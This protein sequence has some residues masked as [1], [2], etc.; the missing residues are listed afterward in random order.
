MNKT[1]AIIFKLAAAFTQVSVSQS[2]E[3]R[4][5]LARE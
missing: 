2:V 3:P 4:P 5:V 1:C